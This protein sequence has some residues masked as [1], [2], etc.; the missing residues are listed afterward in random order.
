MQEEVVFL[1]KL[2]KIA[3]CMQKAALVMAN[4]TEAQ[5]LLLKCGGNL[6]LDGLLCMVMCRILPSLCHIQSSRNT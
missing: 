6:V 3:A 2:P 1:K 5:N 4:Y